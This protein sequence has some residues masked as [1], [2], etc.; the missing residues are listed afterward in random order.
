MTNTSTKRRNAVIAA[1][2]GAALLLGGS[3]Y[4]LWQQSATMSGGTITSGQLAISGEVAQPW[5]ISPD[6]TDIADLG[7]TVGGV[8]LDGLSGHK[9]DSLDPAEGWKMVPGDKVALAFPYTITLVGD[10]LVAALTID[11]DL[12][13]LVKA[14]DEIVINA[15]EN[16]TK[17]PVAL[18]YQLFDDEGQAMTGEEPVSNDGPIFVKYFQDSGNG[19]EQGKL[20]PSN[21][22]PVNDNGTLSVT[23]VLYVY[24]DK[25]ATGDM[26]KSIIEL[27]QS[28]VDTVKATLQQVRCVPNS[29]FN[30]LNCPVVDPDEGE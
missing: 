15:V 19:Q 26:S 12:T 16:L 27:S 1:V 2:A 17:A 25:D 24:F 7:V 5:D 21:I 23:F 18:T 22:I 14:S 3:T 13:N 9:I 8:T 28:S 6:R 20:E 29:N 10:N 30:E 4:A 11:G